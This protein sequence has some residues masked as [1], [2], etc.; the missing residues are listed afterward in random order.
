MKPI[1]IDR[2][3]LCNYCVSI[4]QKTNIPLIYN[5][6]YAIMTELTDDCI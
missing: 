5:F 2:L 4:L 6:R 3:F 1:F